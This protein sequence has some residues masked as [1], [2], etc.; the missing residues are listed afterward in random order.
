MRIQFKSKWKGFYKIDRIVH[1]M[2][3]STTVDPVYKGG[4]LLDGG[5]TGQ[6]KYR[7]ASPTKKRTLRKRTELNTCAF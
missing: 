6:K 4:I 5:P 1:R 7:G 2:E 3:K